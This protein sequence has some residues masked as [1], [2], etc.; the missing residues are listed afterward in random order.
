LEQSKEFSWKK[1]S[2]ETFNYLIQ[3]YKNNIQS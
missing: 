1:T 2:N 3:I